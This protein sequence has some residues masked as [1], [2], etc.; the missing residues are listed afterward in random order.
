[1]RIR[2]IVLDDQSGAPAV[3]NQLTWVRTGLLVLGMDNEMY[4]YS[5][6]KSSKVSQGV[7]SHQETATAAAATDARDLAD[8]NL[9]KMGASPSRMKVTKTL[10]SL[11]S[12]TN[13][14]KRR[15]RG[16]VGKNLHSAK[17]DQR[18]FSSDT[19]LIDYML[20]LVVLITLLST[21]SISEKFL[22]C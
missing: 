11:M 3:P 16:T 10:P 21:S 5:Q 12:T 1:M 15:T 4:V 6:W 18:Y 14:T 17:G 7:V 2:L 20:L 22:I 9:L 13:M 8:Y 19:V